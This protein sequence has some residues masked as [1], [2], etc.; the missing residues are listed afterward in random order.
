MRR[1]D[2]AVA[3]G[4]VV[5]FMDKNR[6]LFRQFVD[7]IA[8]MNNLAANINGRTEGFEGNFDDV[9]G[10]NDAC[11]EAAGLEQKHSFVDGGVSL[12]IAG[13]DRG[14]NRF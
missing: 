7:N 10:A 11:A 2:H 9:D 8:V 4:N 5:D 14:R 12:A 1:V 13:R 3:V 6:T